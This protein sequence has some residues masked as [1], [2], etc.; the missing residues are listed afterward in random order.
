MNK[1]TKEAIKM[2]IRSSNRTNR[3][4]AGYFNRTIREV[5]Q[6]REELIME[7]PLCKADVEKLPERMAEFNKWQQKT[8]EQYCRMRMAENKERVSA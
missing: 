7:K 5:E 8:Y 1:P 2:W 3:E 6:V 4:I